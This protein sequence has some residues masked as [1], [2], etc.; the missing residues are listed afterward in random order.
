MSAP[1]SSQPVNRYLDICYI[2]RHPDKIGTRKKS[3]KWNCK[4]RKVFIPECGHGIHKACFEIMVNSYYRN[5]DEP[6]KC[7]KCPQDFRKYIPLSTRLIKLDEKH[8][9]LI[10][11]T[12]I[13]VAV[14]LAHYTDLIDNKTIALLHPFLA[15]GNTIYVLRKPYRAPEAL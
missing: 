6:L 11:F 8:R 10:R 3:G 1:I 7:G 14:N 2:C 4:D 12:V 13:I 15:I 5:S 9:D